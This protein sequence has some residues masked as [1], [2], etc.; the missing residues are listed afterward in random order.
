[1]TISHGDPSK[2]WGRVDA[3]LLWWESKGSPA[4][5]PLWRDVFWGREGLYVL[6]RFAFLA[7]ALTTVGATKWGT[8][9]GVVLR[10]AAIALTILFLFDIMIVHMSIAFVSRRPAS[11]LR[12]AVLSTFSFFQIPLG[13]AVFYLWN[14]EC[15]NPALT[16][17]RAIYFSTVTGTTLGYGDVVPKP[18]ATLAQLFYR[19]ASSVALHPDAKRVYDENV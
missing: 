10:V 19:A 8:T 1:M 13:F 6:I 16:W 9:A 14:A 4:R 15:F 18:D 3:V 11:L 2:L 7:G 12:S 17:P 5:W